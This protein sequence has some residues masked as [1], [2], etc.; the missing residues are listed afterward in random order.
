MRFQRLGLVVV[1][2]ILS[3]PSSLAA[4]GGK[5]GF[6]PDGRP[7]LWPLGAQELTPQEQDGQFKRK[8]NG[9]VA[10]WWTLDRGQADLESM[11][12]ETRM[13]PDLFVSGVKVRVIWANGDTQD[14][15]VRAVLGMDR[16]RPWGESRK[17]DGLV[18]EAILPVDASIK[19]IQV[20]DHQGVLSWDAEIKGNFFKDGPEKSVPD[21]AKDHALAPGF[22]ARMDSDSPIFGKVDSRVQARRD[23]QVAYIRAGFYPP[24]ELVFKQ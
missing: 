20:I 22:R 21:P 17:P 5:H 3:V 10:V 19:R 18:I 1:A 12:S 11:A 2:A 16:T 23:L 15:P 14:F 24:Y 13:N 7:W 9:E 4:G 8:L 6:H